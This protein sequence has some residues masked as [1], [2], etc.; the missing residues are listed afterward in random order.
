[1][2]STGSGKLGFE[3]ESEC[4]PGQTDMTL[5]QSQGAR[6]SGLKSRSTVETPSLISQSVSANHTMEAS[7]AW[8]G[9]HSEESDSDIDKSQASSIYKQN[10]GPSGNQIKDLGLQ[11]F[12]NQ[13]KIHELPDSA[14][15]HEE[16]ERTLSIGAK[17][18]SDPT[19]SKQKSHS[20]DK[21]IRGKDRTQFYLLDTGIILGKLTSPLKP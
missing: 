12:I 21:I 10:C 1:M 15:R 16:V 4:Q 13:D 8:E 3:P 18:S 14:S 20:M 2:P 6:M 9:Q 7:V 11:H 19:S 5:G 17:R